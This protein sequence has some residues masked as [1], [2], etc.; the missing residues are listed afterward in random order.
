MGCVGFVVLMC[1]VFCWVLEWCWC[2]LVLVLVGVGVG[3]VSVGGVGG[4]VG[5]GGVSGCVGVGCV[6]WCVCVD[7]LRGV[8]L[9][10]KDCIGVSTTSRFSKYRSWNG[11]LWWGVG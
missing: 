11:V 5:V 3:C 1:L 9:D 10:K 8:S 4:C 7:V 6:V 2:W